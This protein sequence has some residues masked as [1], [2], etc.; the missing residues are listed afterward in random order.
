MLL[1]TGLRLSE[2][3]IMN[4]IKK[5]SRE[6]KIKLLTAISKGEI[7]LQDAFNTKAGCIWIQTT[8]N[9][10]LYENGSGDQLTIQQID[11]LKISSKSFQIIVI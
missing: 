10:G 7:T 6:E 5:K 2:D 1:L 8:H 9:P 3:L 11:T 4:N